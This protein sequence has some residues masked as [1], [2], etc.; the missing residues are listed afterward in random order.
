MRTLISWDMA[1]QDLL[2]TVEQLSGQVCKPCETRV[3]MRTFALTPRQVYT[4]RSLAVMSRVR[5]GTYDVHQDQDSLPRTG[6]L[7]IYLFRQGLSFKKQPWAAA[8]SRSGCSAAPPFFSLSSC[9]SDRVAQP[10]RSHH[11]TSSAARPLSPITRYPSLLSQIRMSEDRAALR[12]QAVY[13]AQLLSGISRITARSYDL[14][15][16]EG[17]CSSESAELRAPP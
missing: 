8:V 1:S 4:D 17:G 13:R 3:S 9:P 16:V 10:Q 6:S 14:D 11:A 15:N 12:A 2:P 5:F 7:M